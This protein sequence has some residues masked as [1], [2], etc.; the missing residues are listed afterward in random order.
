[1]KNYLNTALTG[2]SIGGKKS[3]MQ[4]LTSGTFTSRAYD[5]LVLG[6]N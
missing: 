3:N 6:D 2:K 1:M 5:K 4:M